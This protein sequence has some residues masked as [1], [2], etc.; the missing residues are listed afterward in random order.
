[1][2]EQRT[3]NALV[4]GSTPPP[5][6]KEG[7]M[8]S[9][10]M[11][12]YMQ[13]RRAKRR[14]LALDMLGGVCVICQTAEELEFDH[15]DR[16]TKLGNISSP[17]ILDGPMEIFLA[18]VEKCQL[19]CNAHHKEKSEEFGDQNQVPHGGGVSGKRYCKCEPCRAQRRI[20]AKRFR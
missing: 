9:K 3:V 17:K 12:L 16:S 4:G 18:E 13:E 5:G 6:A 11:A 10:N 2:E 8:P 19:L 1:M 20:Y 7:I 15:I 14:K